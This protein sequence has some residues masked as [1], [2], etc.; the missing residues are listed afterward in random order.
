MHLPVEGLRV[1][2]HHINSWK[3]DLAQAAFLPQWGSPEGILNDLQRGAWGPFSKV[4]LPARMVDEH[5]YKW[6]K[7]FADL[8]FKGT[9]LILPQ[10]LFIRAWYSGLGN[11]DISITSLLKSEVC[12]HLSDSQV[13]PTSMGVA[14][15]CSE[16]EFGSFKL[17]PKGSV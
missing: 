17:R 14:H 16:A 12:P 2:Y 5:V 3:S 1:K 9:F 13:A 15:V 7:V 11:H 4:I 8:S 6:W 10:W